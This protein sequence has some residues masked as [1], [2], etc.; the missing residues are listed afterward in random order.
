M[1]AGDVQG[2]LKGAYDS[3]VK[4]STGDIISLEEYIKRVNDDSEA[5]TIESVVSG[6]YDAMVE[7][8]DGSVTTLSEYVRSPGALSIAKE[9]SGGY[10]SIVNLETN[11]VVTTA[12]KVILDKVGGSDIEVEA[13]VGEETVEGLLTFKEAY[14]IKLP[15]VLTSEEE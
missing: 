15:E 9:V 7:L 11:G 1:A 10:E 6:A 5:L 3:L 4:L 14:E 12:T 8:S 13:E 2:Y